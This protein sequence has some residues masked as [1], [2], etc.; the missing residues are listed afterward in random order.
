MGHFLPQQ[1]NQLEEIVART[2][3]HGFCPDPFDDLVS[4][5]E[6][7]IFFQI[8]EIEIAHIAQ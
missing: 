6:V 5:Q 2:H 7:K 1:P 4:F 3:G 8:L